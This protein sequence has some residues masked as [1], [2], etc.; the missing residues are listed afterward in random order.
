MKKYFLIFITFIY[1]F[2]ACDSDDNKE[3]KDNITTLTISN[4]NFRG[5][6]E[7]MYASV[8]FG[9][10]RAIGAGK[11]TKEVPSGTYNI[12]ITDHVF[13]DDNDYRDFF[14]GSNM[15]KHKQ[16]C[17]CP[18]FRTDSIACEEGQNN[19]FNITKNTVV[20]FISGYGYNG[21]VNITGPIQDISDNV[22]M[23]YFKYL[24]KYTRIDI[25]NNSEYN[26]YNVKLLGAGT[27]RIDSGFD[28]YLG[29]DS[30]DYNDEDEIFFYLD[31]SNEYLHCK[32]FNVSIIKNEIDNKYIFTNDTQITAVDYNITD[33]LKNIVEVITIEFS[34]P[35]IE[36]IHYY[37]INNNDEINLGNTLINTSNS[38]TFNIKN[39]G[40]TALL[41]EEIND[42]YINVTDNASGYFNI[43]LQPSNS[44]IASGGNVTFDLQ[45]S[46]LITGI[47]YSA[48]IHIKSNSRNNEEFI[49]KV[50][51]SSSD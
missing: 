45:F 19:Q 14:A 15:Q 46:P 33:T 35:Q 12:F 22:T 23:N 50:V 11:V 6:I 24:R 3:N 34:K 9:F 51:G 27:G 8:D 1:I 43:N 21:S 18:V 36:I 42:N 39:I 40:K 37:K 30:D 49:F 38:F 26:I 47:N 10:Y 7:V 2:F 31:I 41:L 4:L 48:K 16:S 28:M 20:T 29:F 25:Y 44:I 32:F 13:Y 5:Y 17:I